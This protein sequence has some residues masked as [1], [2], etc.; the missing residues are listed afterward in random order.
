MLLIAFKITR[1]N[2]HDSKEA[3]PLLKKLILGLAYTTSMNHKRTH[4]FSHCFSC[5]HHQAFAIRQPENADE[6][7]KIK[8]IIGVLLMQYPK[9]L[10]D[11]SLYRPMRSIDH[12]PLSLTLLEH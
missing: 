2:R 5:L 6:M 1:G 8:P 3:V 7:L 10:R 4:T 11:K 12:Y 9:L